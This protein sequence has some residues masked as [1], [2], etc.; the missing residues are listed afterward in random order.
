MKPILKY[1]FWLF[2]ATNTFAQRSTKLDSLKKVLTSLPME[3]RS[4]SGDTM[5]VRVLCEVA[6]LMPFTQIDSTL[7]IL[8]TGLK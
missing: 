5:R 8:R 7:T 1:V 6:L 3:G 2:M 4:Y